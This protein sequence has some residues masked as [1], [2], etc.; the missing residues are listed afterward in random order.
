MYIDDTKEVIRNRKSKKTDNRMAKKGKL[1][2]QKAHK[3][4]KEI[5]NLQTE[6]TQIIFAAIMLTFNVF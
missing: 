6:Q 5:K 3:V 4:A 1:T 2:S